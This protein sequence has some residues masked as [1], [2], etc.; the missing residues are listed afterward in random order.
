MK[1]NPEDDEI[2]W[3]FNDLYYK[4]LVQQLNTIR[5]LRI[6]VKN[7]RA[8]F[9]ELDQIF[10]TMNY[11]IRK[12]KFFNDTEDRTRYTK[13]TEIRKEVSSAI[14]NYEMAAYRKMPRMQRGRLLTKYKGEV[15][16]KVD[17]YHALLMST[18]DEMNMLFKRKKG[19]GDGGSAVM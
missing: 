16:S 2:A 14:R 3:Q 15:E 5:Y 6:Y 13:L 4:M 19:T 1:D 7:Y 8:V 18:I 12:H 9:Q 17:D 10:I 11:A